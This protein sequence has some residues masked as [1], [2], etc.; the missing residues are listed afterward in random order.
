MQLNCYG[1]LGE[2]ETRR[3]IFK[4][5]WVTASSGIKLDPPRDTG[6]HLSVLSYKEKFQLPQHSSSP[7]SVSSIPY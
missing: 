7:I 2:G 4:L 6:Q 1:L 5:V 3:E